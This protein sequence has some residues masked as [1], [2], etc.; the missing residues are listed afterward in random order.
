ML[1]LD[2]DILIDAARGL[3]AAVAFL[4]EVEADA[5]ISAVTVMELLAGCR[6]KA[7]QRAVSQ[8]VRRFERLPLSEEISDEAIGLLEKYRLSH[9]L[10]IGDALIAATARVYGLTLVSGNERDFRFIEG[11]SLRGR[12]YAA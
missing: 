4:T 6:N 1:V 10:L 7:E 5:A 9:G 11:L 2:T 12:P 8:F 3:E